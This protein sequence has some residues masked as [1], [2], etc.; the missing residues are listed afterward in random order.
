MNLELYDEWKD[1][2]AVKLAIYFL[3]CVLSEFIDKTE[4]NYYL[5]GAKKFCFR[6]RA[7]GFGR[8]RL[9]FLPSKKYDSF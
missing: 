6:H 3:R 7:L 5:Q 8:F 9:S 1:T 2:N 4:G